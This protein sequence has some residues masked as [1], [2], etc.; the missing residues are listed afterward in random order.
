[1]S[2]SLVNTVINRFFKFL[3][4]ARIFMAKITI[5]EK[6]Y[7]GNNVN[8]GDNKI[9]ING[10][11][12]TPE[13]KTIDIKIEGNL[14]SLEFEACRTCIIVGDVLG[15]V[16]SNSGNISVRG[17]VKGEVGSTTGSIE[18]AGD[19]H[20][21]VCTNSG[22]VRVKGNVEGDVTTTSGNISR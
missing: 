10:V 8:I 5:N 13:G 14:E 17:N 22:N 2:I 20:G 21:E 15:D 18:I 6:V 3:S 11:D 1:M 7:E 4:K 19:I 9:F 16:S 12:V